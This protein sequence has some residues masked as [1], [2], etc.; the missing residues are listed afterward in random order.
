MVAMG[1]SA[2]G[3][4]TSGKPEVNKPAEQP[5]AARRVIRKPKELVISPAAAP[6]PALKYRLL[7]SVA[8]LNPGDAAP[9]YL[10]IRYFD[11]NKELEDSWNQIPAKYTEWLDRPSQEFPVA[12]ARKLVEL[13]AKQLKQIE[14]GARRK[15]CDWNY[16]LP[17]QRLE[18]IYLDL[19]DAQN[20]R[21]W[22]RLL[23]IKARME[24][25]ERKFDAAIHTLETGIAFGRHVGEGPFMINALLG[26]A[27]DL[28]MMLESG[29]LD[30]LISEPGSPNL[31][32]ALT[33]LPRP[34]IGMRQAL[35]NERQLCQNLIPELTNA[36]LARP[37]NAQ[38][39]T[40]LLER[41]REGLIK[42]GQRLFPDE[43][44]KEQNPIKLDVGTDLAAF[45]TK[46]LPEAR[47][48]LRTVMNRSEA[49]LAAMSE[50]ELIARYMSDGY[51]ELWD[52]YFKLSYL[53]VVEALPRLR[54]VDADWIAAKQSPLG[55]FAQLL[56]AVQSCLMAE[57][58]L[59][60]KI[61]ALRTVE[62]IRMYAASHNGAMPESLSQITEVPVPVNPITGKPFDYELKGDTASLSG[63][64][65]L[66][67]LQLGA[68]AY[69]IKMRK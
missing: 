29:G 65:P 48:F 41:M 3:Q 56:P 14:I 15:T 18:S 2:F 34:M 42:W 36:E 6:V 12:E 54:K 50:D 69:T 43:S 26:I 32:W 39:W 13:W 28:G 31:Y 35:E 63:V 24:I 11:G 33:A 7:P 44:L 53:P 46:A 17:E 60:A 61:A 52:G 67:S 19:S 66:V 62:A 5:A 30:E 45:K 1:F 25:R 10:R 9:I 38:E 4:A 22:G 40:S 47:R 8:D 64:G 20:M 27:I 23:E 68:P 37:R 57:V 49:Q 51:N 16:T 59:D 55:L 58:R 21:T